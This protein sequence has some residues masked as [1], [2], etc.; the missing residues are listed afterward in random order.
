MHETRSTKQAS[1]LQGVADEDEPRHDCGVL[2]FRP[3]CLQKLNNMKVFMV[4]FT[5]LGLFHGMSNSYF[6]SVI[7]S[8]EKRFNLSSKM[9]GLILSIN[10]V[11]HVLVALIVGHFGGRGHRPRWIALGS[12]MLGVSLMLFALPE[13]VTPRVD[14]DVLPAK[15]GKTKVREQ[16][17]AAPLTPQ[18]TVFPDELLL[19]FPPNET[20][21][22][23]LPDEIPPM[24]CNEYSSDSIV[25]PLIFCISQFFLGIG[26]TTPWVLGLPFIDDNVRNKNTALYFGLSFCGRLIGP[27]LGFALGALCNSL[28]VD[29]S[30]PEF[31]HSDPR[32]ISA[33]YLGFLVTG[34]GMCISTLTMMCF[35]ASVPESNKKRLA[36]S[37]NTNKATR[38]E[39]P[40][41]LKDLPRNLKKILTNAPLMA[42]IL[43]KVLAALVISGYFNFLPKFLAAQYHLGPRTA[44]IASGLS[45]VLAAAIG[46]IS[47]SIV[48]KRYKLQ[49]RHVSLMLIGSAV[50]FG[51]AHF[52]A[53]T[54][55]CD[56]VQ[57]HPNW[58][59]KRVGN[60]TLLES[61]G[62]S[63]SCSQK[64]FAPVC[65]TRTH[66]SYFSPCHAGCAE[67]IHV[68]GVKQYSDC[69]CIA[70]PDEGAILGLNSS[71]SQAAPIVT[72]GFCKTT[73]VNFYIYVTVMFLLKAVASFPLSGTIMLTFKLVEPELKSMANAVSAL[74][75]S[76]FGYFPAPI[77]MGIIIDSTCILWKERAC[78][79]KGSCLLYDTDQFRFRMHFAVGCC[80]F[81]VLGLEVFVYFKVR[82]LTFEDEAVMEDQPDAS[83][84]E[85]ATSVEVSGNP[86]PAGVLSLN[87]GKVLKMTFTHLNIEEVWEGDDCGFDF[88][89]IYEIDAHTYA[90][91]QAVEPC[92]KR[93]SGILFKGPICKL[94]ALP[95]VFFARTEMTIVE[96]C[97]DNSVQEA[98]FFATLDK[99]NS[100]T[101]EPTIVQHSH[102]PV[103]LH[104]TT[105]VLL[106]S[107]LNAASGK[108]YNGNQRTTWVLRTAED[109]TISLIFHRFKLEGGLNCLYDSV[110]IFDGDNNLAV[111]LSQF[112]NSD[113]E[114]R[115]IHTTTNTAFVEFRSD[116]I[117]EMEGFVLAAQEWV[118]MKCRVGRDAE[119]N[120][121][122]RTRRPKVHSHA[123]SWRI[124]SETTQLAMA[125]FLKWDIGD[126]FCGGSLIHPRFVLTAA[127][128]IDGID[129]DVMR[130]RLGSH[131]YTGDDYLAEDA[132]VD[133]IVKHPNY[134]KQTHENDIAVLRLTR[135]VKLRGEI[136]PVCLPKSEADVVPVGTLC[137]ST[138]WGDTEGYEGRN[139]RKSN[140]AW[141][142]PA[143]NSRLKARSEDDGEDPILPKVLNEVRLP[144]LSPDICRLSYGTRLTDDMLCAG[145]M[146]GG[147]DACQGDSGGPF[148]CQQD[149]RW[150]L[151]GVTSWGD[152]CASPNFPGLYAR[153]TTFVSWIEDT[154]ARLSFSPA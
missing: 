99:I 44:S 64:D 141:S 104:A 3:P 15:Y 123:D 89:K 62:A 29:F 58:D 98:G 73:C 17:C 49:P 153:V 40:V 47:G 148:V 121:F 94:Q 81:V 50:A 48:I 144:V 16:F 65:D 115:Q 139:A 151:H 137:A 2:C 95:A 85:M 90:S 140:P 51:S 7:P 79:E 109:R 55:D 127:H 14:S 107:E 39:K 1:S 5:L 41:T 20:Y 12:F 8:I 13:L 69:R 87:K 120:R 72:S 146:E 122:S 80:K 112:C 113:K 63:C 152:G 35:P 100:E 11:G 86:Q 117:L 24:K 102:D 52:I 59:A 9:M 84:L 91:F 106:T 92:G 82:H 118:R 28:Y 129:Q 45:G 88:V 6:S 142:K 135:P 43:C 37:D 66:S 19:S 67:S 74:L 34:M 31:S 57:L 30:Q 60:L 133:R 70:A 154:M 38:T 78:G 126:Q 149:N 131:E 145:F 36:V 147:K 130:V 10:D 134:R 75:M 53:L 71:V 101:F 108:H 68:N 150:V 83:E 97:S 26:A 105:P 96:F 4:C 21:G 116:S 136:L 119:S 56:Q 33:W 114:L 128:C 23:A 77:L 110:S 22:T 93:T 111:K 138:G 42:R 125:G 27:L 54:L 61:C 76:A 46:I 32:W 25:P 132:L 103:I 124:R 143:N 18:T